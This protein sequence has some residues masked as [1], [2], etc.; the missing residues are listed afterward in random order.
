MHLRVSAGDSVRLLTVVDGG[1]RVP[2]TEG[3]LAVQ[4]RV[5]REVE[6]LCSVTDLR[7][8]FC[9][10][11]GQV[12]VHG[13][14]STVFS[15]S[16]REF[17]AGESFHVRPY[18]RKGNPGAMS[19]V[20]EWS[21]LLAA[22][23]AGDIPRCTGFHGV[24]AVLFSAG[25]FSGNYFHDYADIIVPLYLTAR[26][27]EGEVLFLLSDANPWWI[28]KF[29]A[30]FGSLSNYDIINVDKEQG[31][32]CFSR[33][34]VGL[35]FHKELVLDPSRHPHHS[36]QGFRAF[37]RDT[38]SLRRVNAID[39][40]GN[41]GGKRPRLLIVSRNRTRA[42][43]NAASITRMAEELGYEIIV[44]EL[45][46][47]V[48]RSAEIVNSCDVM[49][50]VHGAGL[51]N[52]L[53]LPDHAV[54]IQVIPIGGVE[55]HARVCFGD[56]ARWMGMP[57]LEYRIAENESTLIQQFRPDDVVLKDPV[58]YHK[59]DWDKFKSIYLDQQNVEL[60]VNRFRST[61][62]QAM[63]LLQM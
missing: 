4:E 29:S 5:T 46:Y 8:D 26:S 60:D 59:H 45:D 57:Y 12:R 11:R 22:A 15:V 50:G 34:I 40:K 33:V 43:T 20:R 42:F 13:N 28:R 56:P 53:F 61:L 44:A 18:V 48:S 21:V 24:P 36:M 32:H 14:S 52:F 17:K 31:A 41:N 25:G 27:F 62:V 49:M 54:F 38:Y 30:V 37:L 10:V 47:N 3:I 51:T 55:P 39:L 16:T 35:R 58:S 9:D 6:T 2:Q 63:N 23:D 1:S 19:Y 7:P